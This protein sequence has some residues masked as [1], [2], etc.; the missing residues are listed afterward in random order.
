MGVLKQGLRC[1]YDRLQD[2]AD[3]SVKIRKRKWNKNSLKNPF[4]EKTMQVK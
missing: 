1:D 4:Q 3:G 2:L